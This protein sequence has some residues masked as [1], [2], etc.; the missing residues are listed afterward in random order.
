MEWVA[1]AAA[2]SVALWLVPKVRQRLELS[3]AKHPSLTGHSRWAKRLT[4]WIPGYDY[5]EARFFGSDGAPDAVVARR[6]A[7]FQALAETY[8]QR[9][10]KS[11]AMTRD[12]RQGL[13]DL[14]FTIT[15]SV[16]CK[17]APTLMCCR[18]YAPY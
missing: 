13:S 17:N 10:I 7:G 2:A 12:A 6:K 18:K 14:Q 15:P 3:V 9:F 8:A 5:D 11:S 4:Q 16:P 1:T